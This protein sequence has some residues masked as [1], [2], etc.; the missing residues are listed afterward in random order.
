MSL[1]EMWNVVVGSC[2][3]LRGVPERERQE[4]ETET[5]FEKTMAVNFT[6][7]KH[8]EKK[9]PQIQEPQ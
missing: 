1:G 6:N 9:N 8:E 3:H 5:T 4:S 2:I 7:P